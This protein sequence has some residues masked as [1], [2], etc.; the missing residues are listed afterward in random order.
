M[1][2]YLIYKCDNLLLEQQLPTTY[3]VDYLAIV[4]ICYLMPKHNLNGM[5]L[6][7]VLVN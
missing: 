5:R 2:G 6:V 1:F 3:L 7:E 4:L